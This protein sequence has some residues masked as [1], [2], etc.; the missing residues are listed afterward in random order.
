MKRKRKISP[1]VS[2]HGI[3]DKG[4]AV[5]R[6]AEGKVYFGSGVVPGD[7]ATLQLGRKKKGFS[8]GKVNE[9]LDYSL[10]RQSAPCPH[11]DLCGGCKWQDL[12]YEEQLRQKESSVY[13]VMRRIGKVEGAQWL[14]IIG[15]ASVYQYRNKLE[16]TFSNKR[17]LSDEEVNSEDL[18]PDRNGL[19]F[20][21]PGAFDKVVDIHECLLQG[22]PS[23]AI[24]QR[25]RELANK[26]QIP[27]YD[28]RQNKG[29]LR[30]LVIRTSTLGQTMVVL[31]V[32]K[33][34]EEV[35]RML[36]DLV[37]DVPEI[38]SLFLV[39]NTKV[40]DM[41]TDQKIVHVHGDEYLEE[42]LGDVHFKI[43]P[44]S[45]F[46]TNTQQAELLYDTVVQFANFKG[47]EK[48]VDLYTGIGSIALFIAGKV[49]EVIGIETIPEA[50]ED[51]RMNADFNKMKN[52]VFYTG[53]V[54]DLFDRSFIDKHGRPD[55]LITDPPRAGMHENVVEM[56]KAT[57]IPSIVY[58]SCNPATQARDVQMMS[59]I[60]K[61]E[62]VQ[63]VDL[64]PHTHHVE[65]VALLSLH[66]G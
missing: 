61:V 52:T 26:Y 31:V 38:T 40:N 6:D 2:F 23:N 21:R 50:I 32:K 33:Q 45:F 49:K 55:I 11:F 3:A 22:G 63:P 28:I 65:S 18:I 35:D 39:I 47:H 64:F 16:F 42:K 29:V 15:A 46:Q 44:K 56:L 1:P 20:H 54:K 24:R 30:N 5:G 14:P 66:N 10:Y 25:S 43:N 8:T 36:K 53:D 27:F 9:I 48:V 19:G 60:Y 62:K 13:D 37:K 34:T 59:D 12:S 58:V 41:W 17:W 57:G 4:M 7:K 51:A